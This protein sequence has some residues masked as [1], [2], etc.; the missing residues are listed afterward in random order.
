MSGDENTT[1]HTIR[2]TASSTSGM[3]AKSADDAIEA[4]MA[5]MPTSA[6]IR[7]L[8]RSAITIELESAGD[9]KI[10]VVN[11][12]GAVVANIAQENLMPGVHQ[13]KWNSGIVPNGLYIVRIVH[14]GL[15]NSK[16]VILK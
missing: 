14:N 15:I 6:A 3:L 16:S 5:A 11:V 13:I 8:D 1:Y 10:S 9:A 4:P 2:W 12:N 7:G